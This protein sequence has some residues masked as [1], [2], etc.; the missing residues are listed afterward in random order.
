MGTR[1]S[2]LCDVEPVLEQSVLHR[3]LAAAVEQVDRQ[4]SPW[5]PDSDLSRLNRAAPEAWVALPPEIMAVLVRALEVARQSGGAFDP[6]VGALVDAWALARRATPPTPTPSARPRRPRTGRRTSVWSS[7]P[8]TAA[9]AST[10]P[11]KW[12]CAASP[13][14][15]R[16]TG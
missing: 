9:R 8:P 13:R 2:V 7:T 6:T 3:A 11:C 14:A 5:K 12:I 15:T 16:S 4:M 1:W 10:R